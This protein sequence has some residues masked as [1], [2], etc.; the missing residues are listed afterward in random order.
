[1]AR[2]SLDGVRAHI[3]I[4]KRQDKFLRSIAA[5][6]G[7]TASEHIRRALDQYIDSLKKPESAK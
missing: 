3:M 4:T 6:T 2:Q 7:L 1:M 5:S